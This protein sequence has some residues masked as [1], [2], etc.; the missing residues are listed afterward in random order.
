MWRF[1]GSYAMAQ[2]TLRPTKQGAVVPGVGEKMRQVILQQRC[3]S[4]CSSK[5]SPPNS[6]NTSG[7]ALPQF[8]EPDIPM[9]APDKRAELWLVN[10]LL[11]SFDWLL[12][13][14]TN[15][16]NHLIVWLISCEYLRRAIVFISVQRAFVRFLHRISM[17]FLQWYWKWRAFLGHTHGVLDYRSS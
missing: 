7:F 1:S 11:F 12:D 8:P 2:V 10:F 14:L 3:T 15:S 17:F 9:A 6:L 13:W 5:F 4:R 16:W